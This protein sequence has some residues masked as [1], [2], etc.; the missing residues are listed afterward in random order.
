MRR[1]SKGFKWLSG[2]LAIALLIGGLQ[3]VSSSADN[4]GGRLTV[5]F[6]NVFANTFFKVK[7]V[8]GGKFDITKDETAYNKA[9]DDFFKELDRLE[10]QGYTHQSIYETVTKEEGVTKVEYAPKPEDYNYQG[11]DGGTWHYS[12]NVY[13]KRIRGIYGNYTL[14][15]EL[16][17]GSSKRY[18]YCADAYVK[19]N[20]DTQYGSAN[21]EGFSGSVNL[22]KE[23]VDKLRKIL[24]VGF[25]MNE[26]GS[27]N[28]EEFYK[29]YEADYRPYL[30]HE[31][32]RRAAV[33]GTQLAIWETVHP[34]VVYIKNEPDWMIALRDA[35]LREASKVQLGK[36][37]QPPTLELKNPTL[38]NTEGN[39]WKLNFDYSV[40]GEALDNPL[41][42]IKVNGQQVALNRQDSNIGDGKGEYLFTSDKIPEV[43]ITL[44]VAQNT[45][46]ENAF[47]AKGGYKQSQTMIS[48]DKIKT[49]VGYEKTVTVTAKKTEE[50]KTPKK[51]GALSILKVD[52]K[53]FENG[54]VSKGLEGATFTLE[55]TTKEANA[56]NQTVTTGKD[57]IA[58]FTDIP[59][60]SYK[61]TETKAPAGY[62]KSDWASVIVDDKGN[63]TFKL[64]EVVV[65]SENGSSAD[66]VL[67]FPND[68]TPEDPK[69]K[70]EP[71]KGELKTKVSIKVTR[72]AE[73]FIESNNGSA[74]EV[75]PNTIK[76][77]VIVKDTIT[78]SGLVKGADYSVTGKLMKVVD[79]KATETGITVTKKLTATDTNGTW[80]VEFSGEKVA[81]LINSL[82]DGEKLVVYETATRYTDKE[83][84]TEVIKHEDPK[85][86]NQTIVVPKKPEKPSIKT[87]VGIGPY[88]GKINI[89]TQ[90]A[91]GAELSVSVNEIANNTAVY[92]TIIYSGLKPDTQYTLYAALVKVVNNNYKDNGTRVIYENKEVRKTTS[93]NGSGAWEIGFGGSLVNN[94]LKS[95][96]GNEKLVVIEK[97]LTPDFV[98]HIDYN[99]KEQTILPKKPEPKKEPKKTDVT[100]TKYGVTQHYSQENL[101]NIENKDFTEKDIESEVL[102]A[103][104]STIYV[105][106]LPD[107]KGENGKKIGNNTNVTYGAVEY[108]KTEKIALE[109][110][111][112]T[113]KDNAGKE[114][115][116]GIT[117]N[118]DGKFTLK[119]LTDG[120]YTLEE[121]FIPESYKQTEEDKKTLEGNKG[122]SITYTSNFKTGGSFTI[123]VKDGKVTVDGKAISNNA[124]I[125]N[126][127]KI[128]VVKWEK[129]E[130]KLKDGENVGKID[131]KIKLGAN[132]AKENE[133]L[134]V[135]EAEINDNLTDTIIYEGLIP[136]EEY[137][138]EA[139][140]MRKK[141][142]ALDCIATA[143]AVYTVPKDGNGKG[144]VDVTFTSEVTKA[145]L[146][147]TK[148]MS[149][150]DSFVVYEKLTSKNNYNNATEA[151]TSDENKYYTKTIKRNGV[152]TV[153]IVT[154]GKSHSQILKHEEPNSN[155]QSFRIV[156]DYD[157]KEGRISTEVKINDGSSSNGN[158][159]TV[160]Y[161]TLKD[162]KIIDTISYEGLVPEEVYTAA[163]KL[164]LVADGKEVKEVV[165]AKD[166]EF[167]ST[168]DGNGTVDVPFEVTGELLEL[169]KKLTSNKKF[170]VY[171]TVTS[172]KHFNEDGSN[173]Y[174][175]TKR[176]DTKD[177]SKPQV[178][179]HE[180]PNSNSQSFRVNPLPDVTSELS[181]IVTIGNSSGTEVAPATITADELKNLTSFTDTVSYKGLIPNKPYTLTGSLKDGNNTL[182]TATKEFTP[183][184]ENGI[185]T[186]TFILTPEAKGLLLAGKSFVV[187]ETATS[188]GDVFRAED[189]ISTNKF[190]YNGKVYNNANN[191]LWHV[192]KHENAND[193]KQTFTV[194][195]NRKVKEGRLETK[196]NI[197][198]KNFDTA[199]TVVSL[200]K[201]EFDRQTT[202]S[203]DVIYTDL[204]P[205]NYYKIQ[206][207]LIDSANGAIIAEASQLI[208]A[209][210]IGTGV[211]R[212]TFDITDDVRAKVKAG[213]RYV[214]YE[215]ATSD[216]DVFKDGDYSYKN[217]EDE[218]IYRKVG[219]NTKHVVE[220][221]NLG[222]V[223]Q[224]FV[225]TDNPTPP[226][227]PYIPPYIPYIPY[228]PIIPTPNPP[229]P[230]T[231]YIPPTP[232]IPYI[233]VIPNNPTP[234]TNPPAPPTP[235]I[236][237]TPPSVPPAP[238]HDVP[239]IRIPD[240]PTPEG[241]V[242]IEDPE[243]DLG[244]D[245]T[246]KGDPELDIGEDPTPRGGLALT[247][248][249]KV[250]FIWMAGILLLLIVG[251]GITEIIRIKKKND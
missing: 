229:T 127:R 220:H 164:M 109:G 33:G 32:N 232:V 38:T 23:T 132:G 179:K 11:S 129:L 101:V 224:T 14:I 130:P 160:D 45:E 80:E 176:G 225:V 35:I 71:K 84:K 186:V 170:V 151:N 237:F 204:I 125:V 231:P 81:S 230:P 2:L 188:N 69:P 145:I 60:G 173:K 219:N 82:K 121:T 63:V 112:F 163:G 149:D 154:A 25:R 67:P 88:D 184:S 68:K 117:T 234:P 235:L 242:K 155:S 203:D 172:K 15:Y 17:N 46:K 52:S 208:R 197:N 55:A 221:K 141:G 210:S 49:K 57:G 240:D 136:G 245:P 53:D 241:T 54:K 238:K 42:D 192:V 30:L 153:E 205:N 95:L 78:Y 227:P 4:S 96:K 148:T 251:F 93:S 198:G 34:G 156:K 158:I 216:E 64:N 120:I 207:Q 233:P 29:R 147:A 58:R 87:K 92:D 191:S 56:Y 98:C 19:A 40:T 50:P 137:K 168:K 144:S 61:L 131:T 85:D 74:L 239:V 76:D 72:C 157:K 119:G 62:N 180:D 9:K 79:G 194:T 169:A 75:N 70:P 193:R 246:P 152:E 250:N 24:A 77:D 94:T 185:E 105:T 99:D 139:Q 214:V 123:V 236:P 66:L 244:E 47:L 162:A 200:T 31:R 150:T 114:V 171:E 143:D 183:T 165:T 218:I 211:A 102:T 195:H 13:H 73:K 178:L 249:L 222:D 16:T 116:K 18:A 8:D 106:D 199:N 138:I 10:K 6:V 128:K 113:L 201:A 27:D 111:K 7:R 118:K 124:N 134:Q 48:I 100:F 41:F 209:T 44:K 65:T 133:I 142:T 161:A 59:E 90:A 175:V 3:A 181:T 110:V 26:D 89:T 248:G 12:G 217:G 115:Q 97:L 182:V 247:G 1:K 213:G 187:Y 126:F 140:I 5:G 159:L 51:Y 206:G 43:A 91:A 243:L 28:L 108:E 39:N 135:P 83:N 223:R 21:L 166:V 177:G 215:T 37:V 146:E 174:Y 86:T 22:S 103:S 196:V 212:I 107:F 228:I 167:T 226:T 104:S 202:F 190:I 122:Y 36:T 189:N 20:P